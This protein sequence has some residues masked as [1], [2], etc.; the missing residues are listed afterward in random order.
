M[1]TQSAAYT[2]FLKPGLLVP[3]SRAFFLEPE[4]KSWLSNMLCGLG[5]IAKSLWA[6]VSCLYYEGE[7]WKS[8]PPNQAHIRV[9]W[10]FGIR[11]PRDPWGSVFRKQCRE[12]GKSFW[13]R[14]PGV[15]TASTSGHLGDLGHFISEFQFPCQQNGVTNN[16]SLTGLA[17]RMKW[18]SSG[19]ERG[20]CSAISGCYHL[21]EAPGGFW[22]RITRRDAP[23]DLFI[24]SCTKWHSIIRHQPPT[25]ASKLH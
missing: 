25:N 3:W 8:G 4:F 13:S 12:A 22:L 24:L 5:Q 23:L 18:T 1:I 7:Q 16:S 9:M 17:V 20:R 11:G 21:D 15:Q 19:T 6:E 14:L 2:D 10:A